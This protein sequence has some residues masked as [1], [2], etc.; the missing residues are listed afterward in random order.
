MSQFELDLDNYF[1][2]PTQIRGLEAYY[3]RVVEVVGDYKYQVILM[4][5]GETFPESQMVPSHHH[6]T[7]EECVKEL[8]EEYA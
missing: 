2:D 1:Y 4:I 8:L 3:I 6:D 7:V 5:K